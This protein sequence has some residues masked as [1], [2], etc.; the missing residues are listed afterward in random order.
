VLYNAAVKTPG[1]A[2]FWILRVFQALEAAGWYA[3]PAD[4]TEAATYPRQRILSG[5]KGLQLIPLDSDGQEQHDRLLR[6]HRQ[7]QLEREAAWRRQLEDPE[8]VDEQP[9]EDPEAE[10]A[11][12]K[13]PPPPKPV[14]ASDLPR[15]QAER[16]LGLIE[17]Y[18]LASRQA[19]RQASKPGEDRDALFAASKAAWNAIIAELESIGPRIQAGSYSDVFTP[20]A[21]T[22]KNINDLEKELKHD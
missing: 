8:P 13:P 7:A 12:Q 21:L 15:D 5:L 2:Q 10:D 4:Y 16:L 6:E 9:E 19:S 17:A 11:P 20:S 18:R 14:H 1:K 3:Q 22:F